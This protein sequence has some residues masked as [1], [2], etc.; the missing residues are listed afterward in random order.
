[1]KSLYISGHFKL[2]DDF[3]GTRADAIRLLADYDE[4][5]PDLDFGKEPIPA[6]LKSI[7]KEW[8]DQ[9][10]G[11]FCKA[12]DKG[13]RMLVQIGISVDGAKYVSAVEGATE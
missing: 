1:M 6:E 3:V 8:H 4:S 5:I 7:S 13:C 12:V 2:P 11:R 10:W 9:A